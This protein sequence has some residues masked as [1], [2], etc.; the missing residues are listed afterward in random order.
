MPT[1]ILTTE[2]AGLAPI[3]VAVPLTPVTAK[4]ELNR[5]E[6]FFRMW[7]RISAPPTFIIDVGANHGSWT[8]SALR[9]FPE[10]QFIMVEPQLPLKAMSRDLL[11][12]PNVRWVNAG[13]S[14]KVGSLKLTLPPRH[15]RASFVMTAEEAQQAGFPQIEVPILTLNKIAADE[16]KIPT[17][18][19]ID[20]EG[21]DLKALHGA[22]DLF[23]RTEV[24]LVECAICCPTFKNSLQAVCAYMGKRGY[25]VFDITDLNRSPKDG[26]LW[27]TE[28]AFLRKESPALKTLTSY[29]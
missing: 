13:I 7:Q 8:R 27:L 19:K 9:F 23:G 25:Q 3:R 4:T 24:F 2:N 26:A 20:A 10:A 11:A 16:Q 17:I 18:I 15:A 5:V 6:M 28:V 29:D 12:R 1:E 21:F 14:D 22:S